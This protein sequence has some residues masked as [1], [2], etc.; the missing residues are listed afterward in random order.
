[1][2]TPP[3]SPWRFCENARNWHTVLTDLAFVPPHWWFHILKRVNFS[4]KSAVKTKTTRVVGQI[5][6]CRSLVLQQNVVCA[7]AMLG[8]TSVNWWGDA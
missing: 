5:K 8:T 3:S 1:M 4:G 2:P 6:V 7:D